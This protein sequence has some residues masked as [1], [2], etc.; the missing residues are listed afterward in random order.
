MSL[1]VFV[2]KPCVYIKHTLGHR[3]NRGHLHIS[4]ENGSLPWQRVLVSPLW[5]CTEQR[6][7]VLTLPSLHC[8]WKTP[9]ELYLLGSFQV[10]TDI[11][12][13]SLGKNKTKSR[14]KCTK[15]NPQITS[16][17]AK[18]TLK[19]TI[20]TLLPPSGFRFEPLDFS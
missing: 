7:I 13:K 19:C 15:V 14:K 8:Y 4:G 20:L 5:K 2:A 9:A 12:R 18:V 3:L 16:D 10:C 6:H 17:L 11:L 1:P